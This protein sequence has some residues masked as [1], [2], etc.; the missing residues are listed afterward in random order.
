MNTAQTSNQHQPQFISQQQSQFTSQYQP[1]F[2]NQYQPQLNN[3][4]P[5]T[6]FVVD[7]SRLN[8]DRNH[9]QHFGPVSTTN[10]DHLQAVDGYGWPNPG[11]QPQQFVLTN[12]NHS[13]VPQNTPD[14]LNSKFPTNPGFINGYEN[15]HPGPILQQYPVKQNFN[16]NS[17]WINANNGFSIQRQEPV[18]DYN[19]QSNVEGSQFLTDQNNYGRTPNSNNYGRTSGNYD[20]VQQTHQG[21]Y[22]TEQEQINRQ[23]LNKYRKLSVTENPKPASNINPTSWMKDQLKGRK[24]S[25]QNSYPNGYT[26]EQSVYEEFQTPDKPAS[27]FDVN[28]RQ[29]VGYNEPI[30]IQSAYG[31]SVDASQ[32]HTRIDYRQ[33]SFTDDHGYNSNPLPNYYAPPQYVQQQQQPYVFHPVPQEEL[34]TN[35]HPKMNKD[36][37]IVVPNISNPIDNEKETFIAWPVSVQP[38]SKI[39]SKDSTSNRGYPAKTKSQQ[40]PADK[41]HDNVVGATTLNRNYYKPPPAD[42]N[43]DQSS[44]NSPTAAKCPNDF[45]GIKPHPTDCSKFLSC[46]F[47]RTFEMVCGPGTL[48]N[49]AISVCD[50]PYNVQCNRT[51]VQT[52][53]VATTTTEQEDYGYTSFPVEFTTERDDYYVSPT[54]LRQDFEPDT[55]TNEPSITESLT[56][57]EPLENENPA[58]LETLPTENRQLKILRNPTNVDL[59]DNFLLNATSG[60]QVPSK[61]TYNRKENIA[62]RIDLKPNSTQSIRLRGSPKFSEGFLQIQDK[63]FQWGVVCDEPN[64]WTIEKADIVCKQLGF[65]RYLH[66]FF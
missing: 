15:Y 7:Q 31:Q 62:V 58:I 4:L 61:A 52:T 20:N 49:P 46:S 6:Q 17:P 9:P 48:F 42:N 18:P 34:Q 51:T 56:E 60:V 40:Y 43:S 29:R 14:V 27:T 3:P 28:N 55:S 24:G 11:V 35:G 21:T 59:S 23:K 26:K 47:G 32:S 57:P 33:Q 39:Q 2:A 16:Q 41:R 38:N 54:D 12:Q 63:P 66:S 10:N 44:T 53:V 36:F 50:Y 5:G 37:R 8:I 25:G 64:S 22:L 1:Q 45:N 65:N 30:N 13:F 19:S